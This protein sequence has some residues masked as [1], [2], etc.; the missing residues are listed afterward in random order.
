MAKLPQ[1]P[2]AEDLRRLQPP[3]YRLARGHWLARIGFAGGDHPTAWNEL[4]HWGPGGSRFDHHQ[5]DARGQPCHQDRGILYA[6][7]QAQTCI[8]EVFQRTRIVDVNRGDP[9]LALWR[10]GADLD[11][12]DLTGAFVTRMGAS[13]A[14]H[15]GHRGRARAWAMAIHAAWPMLHGIAYCSSMDGNAV[16]YALTERALQREPFP[17]RPES[18]R[19]LAD[20]LMAD[21]VDAA[22]HRVGYAVMR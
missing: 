11:L 12:L 15:S 5:R 2:A 7:A 1:P 18:L 4:R 13:T 21:L 10:T 22:A 19:M 9:Y 17:R 16:A 6:A 20:P 3:V 8:A 14:I